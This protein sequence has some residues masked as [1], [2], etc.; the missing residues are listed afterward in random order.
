MSEYKTQKWRHSVCK[1]YNEHWFFSANL[2]CSYLV[3]ETFTTEKIHV[4]QTTKVS[5]DTVVFLVFNVTYFRQNIINFI[6]DYN[7]TMQ[8]AKQQSITI[9]YLLLSQSQTFFS[10]LVSQFSSEAWSLWNVEISYEVNNR[11]P[12]CTLSIN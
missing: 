1:C 7:Y 11:V 4:P 9:L 3:T 6:Q 10:P 2:K 8:I 12:A 5:S